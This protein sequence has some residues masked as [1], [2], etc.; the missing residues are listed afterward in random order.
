MADGNET[1]DRIMA[2][3][4]SGLTGQWD[5][6]RAYLQ[7]QM[8]AYKD[9]ELSQEII[10][11]CGRLMYELTPEDLRAELDQVMRGRD[12]QVTETLNEVAHNMQTGNW[13]AA[14]A[15]IEPLAATCDDLIDSGWCA[16]D[17][18]SRY[19]DFR[20]ATDEIVWRARNDDPRTVRR[21]TDPFA[22][23]YAALGSC[24]VEARRYDE[25]LVACEKAIRWNP[26]NVDA[27]FELGVCHKVLGDVVAYGRVLDEL[28]PYVATAYDLA[29]YH[30][31]MGYLRIEQGSLQVAAAHLVWSLL[32]DT[33]SHAISELAYIKQEYGKD[34]TNMAFDEALAILV[35]ADERV[36]I[37]ER[38][39]QALVQTLSV[40]MQYRDYGTALSVA[41]ELYNFTGDDTYKDI[42]CQLEETLGLG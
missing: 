24:L 9:H 23:I 30:C 28:Y 3:I 18:K 1:F 29:H 27:R 41:R 42:I 20:S 2:H 17:S 32:F 13:A 5:L 40:S 34:Y 25:A 8:E 11:S 16:D 31:A 21:A 26:A 39:F 15:I 33:S 38:T 6:D 10:R 4:R 37:D 12:D 35:E 7:A 14:S 19:F 22:R 36:L